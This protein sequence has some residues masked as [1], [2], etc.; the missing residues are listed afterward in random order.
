MSALHQEI[1]DHRAKLLA[2]QGGRDRARSNCL[3]EEPRYKT[4]AELALGMMGIDVSNSGT[5]DARRV[6]MHEQLLQ[7][8]ADDAAALLALKEH[9]DSC[10]RELA[11][12]D[13]IERTLARLVRRLKDAT[14][15]LSRIDLA[16]TTEEYAAECEAYE[17]SK[18]GQS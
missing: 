7:A 13:D 16:P 15:L 14:E 11:T 3:L 1:E 10:G 5:P 12:D 4:L 8:L 18:E 6:D 17:A 9:Q 2:A